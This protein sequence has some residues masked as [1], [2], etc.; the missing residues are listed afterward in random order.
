MPRQVFAGP[1]GARNSGSP[2]PFLP[3]VLTSLVSF[4]AATSAAAVHSAAPGT[5]FGPFTIKVEIA[6]V[7]QGVFR[8]VEGLA[9]ASEVMVR[10]VDSLSVEAP[11]ALKG[12]RLVLKRPFDPLL[13][14]LWRWRQ[15][16]V[17]GDP[18]K[19]DGDIFI[20]N[21]EGA[22]VSHWIFHKGWPSRWEVPSLVSDSNEPAEE[23][24]EIVHT[25]LSEETREGF[26]TA[27]PEPTLPETLA[28]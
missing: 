11:G 13:T 21:A 20:F 18:Q 6:G 23:I 2:P 22:L 27:A 10:Q 26:R 12:A 3:L 9:S 25:G 19:R 16:V 1:T 8:A 28:P 4:V 24:V 5:A 14:G 15:S 17:D 7:T